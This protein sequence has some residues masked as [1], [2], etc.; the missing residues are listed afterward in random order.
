[1]TDLEFFW[2]ADDP[3]WVLVNGTAVPIRSLDT[4]LKQQEEDGR[5]DA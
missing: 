5:E 2:D 3:D 4:W 1:M